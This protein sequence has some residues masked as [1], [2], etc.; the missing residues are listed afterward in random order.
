MILLR[1]R[2]FVESNIPEAINAATAIL[3]RDNDEADLIDRVRKAEQVCKSQSEA[4]HASYEI[5]KAN[6]AHIDALAAL[7]AFRNKRRDEAGLIDWGR[8]A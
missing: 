3:R 5:H 4:T 6:Y 1:A 2:A 8:P 7:Q